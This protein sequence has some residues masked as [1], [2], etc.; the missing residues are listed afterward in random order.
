M[1][2]NNGKIFLEKLLSV[3]LKVIGI[4][5]TL[6]FGIGTLAFVDSPPIDIPAII[7]CLIFAVVGI[8]VFIAGNRRGRL[9]R[10]L[11]DYTAFMKA[12]SVCS[13]LELAGNVGIHEGFVREDLKKLMKAGYFR[14]A[15]FDAEKDAI[16]FVTRSSAA[17][18]LPKAV[19][20]E[21]KLQPKPQDLVT[22]VCDACG[23]INN[24]PKNKSCSCEYCGSPIRP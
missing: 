18:D 24:V 21:K 20:A 11:N 5:I 15:H 23:G 3:A 4:A 19:P 12:S 9:L 17:D 7:V 1:D 6:F 13:V 8:L 2:L 14:N 22:V 10:K 16:V